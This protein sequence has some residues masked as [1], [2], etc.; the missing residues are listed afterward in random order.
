[1]D[2]TTKIIIFYKKILVIIQMVVYNKI[3]QMVATKREG[4]FDIN[5]SLLKSKRMLF[6]VSQRKLAESLGISKI[7]YSLKEN[8][9]YEFTRKEIFKIAEIL[10][11]DME[12]INEIFFDSKL[13]NG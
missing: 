11:L 1:M 2:N 3:I 9:K 8:G 4:V 6:Q 13:P 10:E 12:D 7:T 5:T